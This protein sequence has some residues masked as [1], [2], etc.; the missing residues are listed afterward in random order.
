MWQS[1]S[2]VR[3]SYHN[4]SFWLSPILIVCHLIEMWDI[5]ILIVFIYLILFNHVLCKQLTFTHGRF[6]CTFLVAR[7]YVSL[8]IDR[9]LTSLTVLQLWKCKSVWK[10]F[11]LQL[12]TRAGKC[13]GAMFTIQTEMNQVDELWTRDCYDFHISQFA[14]FTKLPNVDLWKAY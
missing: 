9:L 3:F 10:L 7:V 12:Y 2:S 5:E 1:F 8:E 11:N 13:V 4:S 6:S 14:I